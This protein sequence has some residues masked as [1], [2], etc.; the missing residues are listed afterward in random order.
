M[1]LGEKSGGSRLETALSNAGTKKEKRSLVSNNPQ[2]PSY[3][4]PCLLVT[5]RRDC[6]NAELNIVQAWSV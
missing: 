5:Y 2:V 4:Q 3:R 6:L 1:P